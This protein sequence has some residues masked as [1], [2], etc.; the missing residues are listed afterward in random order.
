VNHSAGK[1]YTVA[2]APAPSIDEQLLKILTPYLD[3]RVVRK[4]TQKAT[5]TK[6]EILGLLPSGAAGNTLANTLKERGFIEPVA[7]PN[8]PKGKAVGVHYLRVTQAGRDWV[9]AQ[10]SPTAALEALAGVL[11]G[12][13]SPVP[14]ID[15][16]PIEALTAELK[17]AAESVQAM[18][19]SAITVQAQQAEALQ[20]MLKQ[21][22]EAVARAL[23]EAT[24]PPTPPPPPVAETAAPPATPGVDVQL[25]KNTISEEL[26]RW[27]AEKPF[28]MPLDEL[29]RKLQATMPKLSIG[30]FH[31]ALREMHKDKQLVLTGWAKTLYEIPAPELALFISDKVMYYV[32][33]DNQ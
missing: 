30:H 9:L 4:S 14:S 16:S 1:G 3:G 32:K 19:Q 6:P 7:D 29:Y 22:E 2:K 17:R 23:S 24:L 11:K 15:L 26:T 25:L 12:M 10:L 13:T 28:G 31:D 18:V 20:R 27:Y 21:T 5:K 8:Q 33:P